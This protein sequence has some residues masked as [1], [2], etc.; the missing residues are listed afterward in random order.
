MEV[1]QVCKPDALPFYC[2]RGLADSISGASISTKL[3]V[4][5]MSKSISGI[6]VYDNAES[7][8][9]Y[10]DLSSYLSNSE[11]LYVVGK[12][13]KTRRLSVICFFYVYHKPRSDT[14]HNRKYT[15]EGCDCILH[16]Y[17]V[18]RHSANSHARNCG[19]LGLQ[20]PGRLVAF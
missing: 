8:G 4:R 2:L 6:C 14:C 19:V 17:V 15:A 9:E 7:G 5:T 16:I 10:L 11:L 1:L 3:C 18:Q 13:I 12:I 20:E